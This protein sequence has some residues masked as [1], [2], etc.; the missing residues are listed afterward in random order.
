M[1]ESFYLLC[2]NRSNEDFITNTIAYAVKLNRDKIAPNIF[3][4]GE[5]NEKNSS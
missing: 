3:N 2:P 4:K 1:N 5:Q